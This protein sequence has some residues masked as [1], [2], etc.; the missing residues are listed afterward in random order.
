MTPM[1]MS[2]QE[3]GKLHESP[4]PPKGLSK[5]ESARVD[6]IWAIRDKLRAHMEKVFK[7]SCYE[8]ENGFVKPN[9]FE[10]I[11]KKVVSETVRFVRD[12]ILEKL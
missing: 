10:H 2:G 9:S 7:D 12:E 6:K 11:M 3:I 4:S 5:A 8:S 1:T